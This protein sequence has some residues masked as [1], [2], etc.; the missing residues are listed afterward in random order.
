MLFCPQFKILTSDPLFDGRPKEN[1]LPTGS[2][3]SP[4]VN[5]FDQNTVGDQFFD[6]ALTKWNSLR[7]LLE[8]EVFAQHVFS[9]LQ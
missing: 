9:T 8:V 5:A 7:Q 6:C 1:S 2:R 4:K 3:W